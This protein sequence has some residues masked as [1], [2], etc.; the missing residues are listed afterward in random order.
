V[1]VLHLSQRYHKNL[2]IPDGVGLFFVLSGY[3]IT[4]LLLRERESKGR[5]SLSRFWIRRAFRILPPMYAYVL[6]VVIYAKFVAISLSWRSVLASA[7]FLQNMSPYPGSALL[8]HT[9][10]L[11]VEE[12]FYIVWPVLMVCSYKFCGRRG[13][14]FAALGMIVC[15]PLFRVVFGAMHSSY[16]HHHVFGFMPSRMDSLGVGCFLALAQGTGFFENMYA[17]VSSFWWVAALG[18]LIG[19]PLLVS[20]SPQFYHAFGLS[21]DAVLMGLFILWSARNPESIV[22]RFLNNGLIAEIGV[23]SYSIYLWQTFFI[24]TGTGVRYLNEMPL[25]LLGIAIAALLSRQFVEKPF[26]VLRDKVL[27]MRR[28]ARTVEPGEGVLRSS[29]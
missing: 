8:E 26:F 12:Q 27:A 15:A 21:L 7:L 20:K 5:V 16:L 28:F 10:S 4:F 22:G 29:G 2:F 18:F 13:A 23:L 6:F 25:G 1:I 17:K 19:T 11:A 24:H 9:W 14:T 3:L